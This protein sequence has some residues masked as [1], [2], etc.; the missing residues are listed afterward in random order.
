MERVIVLAHATKLKGSQRLISAFGDH[1]WHYLP[2]ED[3]RAPKVIA[4]H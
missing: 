1:A 4:E 3:K 2:S